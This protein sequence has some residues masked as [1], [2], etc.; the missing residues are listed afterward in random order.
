MAMDDESAV[1]GVESREVNEGVNERDTTDPAT[2]H[3]PEYKIEET[4]LHKV[5]LDNTII[6]V[7]SRWPDGVYA[8]SPIPGSQSFLATT[9][10]WIAY[11]MDE[12]AQA[13]RE[14]REGEHEGRA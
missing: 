14:K 7:I 10:R 1:G 13:E 11:R 12:I 9:L 3:Y 8:F 6:G 4:V 2:P 5:M